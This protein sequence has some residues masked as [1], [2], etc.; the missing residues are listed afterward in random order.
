MPDTSS[1]P[2]ISLV[3]VGG[4]IVTVT[5]AGWLATRRVVQM[6]PLQVL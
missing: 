5:L 4:G 3:G 6:S 1:W 2:D